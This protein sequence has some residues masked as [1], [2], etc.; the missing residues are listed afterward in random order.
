VALL[1]GWGFIAASYVAVNRFLVT[2]GVWSGRSVDMSAYLRALSKQ[3]WDHAHKFVISFLGYFGWLDLSMAPAVL[4]AL[5]LVIVAGLLLAVFAL[6]RPRSATRAAMGVCFAFVVLAVA[7]AVLFDVNGYVSVGQLL[8]QGRYIL[9]ALPALA[10][11]L[12]AGLDTVI[13]KRLS[14]ALAPAVVSAAL[15]L[16]LA[17]LATLWGAFYVA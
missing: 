1:L 5:T 17:G 14:W 3:G 9:P 6:V 13:P 7:T 8:T 10:I 4:Y 2:H 11:L 12:V 16:N 15:C